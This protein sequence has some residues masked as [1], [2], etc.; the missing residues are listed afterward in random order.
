[1]V[2]KFHNEIR[3]KTRLSDLDGLTA[4]EVR[5][6]PKTNHAVVNALIDHGVLKTE[7]RINPIN[8][9]PVEIVPT[10]EFQRF[11]AT[12]VTLFE[13]TG[14]RGVRHL[15]VKAE[16]SERGIKPAFD[17]EVFHASFY[18]RKELH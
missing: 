14:E 10:A 5:K 3:Q 8:R 1:V 2:L 7:R 6:D 4:A 15:Y 18:R 9:C 16:L 12:Y 11:R 17:S 13:I